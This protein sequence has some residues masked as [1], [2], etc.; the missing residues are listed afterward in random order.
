MSFTPLENNFCFCGKEGLN[1]RCFG[2]EHCEHARGD[3]VSVRLIHF[4]E[5][6]AHMAPNN[7]LKTKVLLSVLS[8]PCDTKFDKIIY[9]T[10]LN[11]CPKSATAT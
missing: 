4:K 10:F 11:C 8:D 1:V 2:A 5:F 7:L 6:V 9:G 3:I